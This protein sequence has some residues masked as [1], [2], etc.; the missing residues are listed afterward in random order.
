VLLWES[1]DLLTA[2]LHAWTKVRLLRLEPRMA[3]LVNQ[4]RTGG[5]P[6]VD[7]AG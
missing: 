3:V 1:C 5:L 7:L 4:L 2:M 6:E